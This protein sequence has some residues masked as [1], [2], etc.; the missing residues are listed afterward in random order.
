MRRYVCDQLA[1]QL[2]YS[3]QLG[4]LRPYA[5]KT[6]L[7]LPCLIHTLLTGDGFSTRLEDAVLHGCVPVII[8]DN[9]HAPF[10]SILAYE[11]FSVRVAE[12]QVERLPHILTEISAKELK[13]LQ[14]NLGRVWH[15]C[16]MCG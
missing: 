16:A 9:V 2:V 10:E 7:L 12:S 8:Q 5:N 1:K 15:R 11:A 13:R 3:S 4:D 14:R 6:P